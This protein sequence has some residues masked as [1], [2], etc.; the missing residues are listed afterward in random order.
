MQFIT[1]SLKFRHTI[2]VQLE[3]EQSRVKINIY[4]Q[5]YSGASY[6]LINL[7]LLDTNFMLN[8]KYKSV[9]SLPIFSLPPKKSI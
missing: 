3:N 9:F 8:I 5:A 4:F 1:Y 6:F 2:K 7:T